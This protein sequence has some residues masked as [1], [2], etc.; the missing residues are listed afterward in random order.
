M[1]VAYDTS[2]DPP[3]RISWVGEDTRGSLPLHLSD[4]ERISD[5]GVILD[6]NGASQPFKIILADAECQKCHRMV[7]IVRDYLVRD[8]TDI[9]PSSF[10]QEWRFSEGDEF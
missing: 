3:G 9:A 7:K 4:L 8:N 5:T 10:K 6:D 2:Y 1:V